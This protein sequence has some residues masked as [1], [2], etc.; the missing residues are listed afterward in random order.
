MVATFI[1]YPIILTFVSFWCF[2]LPNSSFEN[3]ISYLFCL[4]FM[5]FAGASLGFAF[6]TVFNDP[7]LASKL[8]ENLAICF[9]MGAGMIVN[10][11]SKAN[12]FVR[13]L[14]WISP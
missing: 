6:G 3:F 2:D 4:I 9:Q 1:Y 12:G 8:L 14:G 5:M 7:L 13:F 11:S 10:V